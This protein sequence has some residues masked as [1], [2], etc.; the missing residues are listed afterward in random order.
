MIRVLASM[1]IA[2]LF[3]GCAFDDMMMNKTDYNVRNDRFNDAVTY[4]WFASTEY[5][6]TP[7]LNFTAT[8]V[9]GK[10]PTNVLV[11]ARVKSSQWLYLKCNRVV[12]LIDGDRLEPKIRHE[13]QVARTSMGVETNEDISFTVNADTARKIANASLVEYQI[14]TDE[15]V[16]EA[17]DREGLIKVLEDSGIGTSIEH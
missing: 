5:Y 2:L 8:K 13:G 6:R 1:L 17:E 14:C 12:M 7:R 4:N 3:S 15:F 16:L 10:T 11:T 9:S